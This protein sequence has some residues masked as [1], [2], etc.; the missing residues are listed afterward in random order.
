M[1]CQSC[2]VC[3]IICFD[4]LTMKRLA[5]IGDRRDK[6]KHKHNS[7][8][9]GCNVLCGNV[10]RDLIVFEIKALIRRSTEKGAVE[11]SAAVEHKCIHKQPTRNVCSGCLHSTL[12]SA[13]A[14]QN[15]TISC[16]IDDGTFFFC[17]FLS[18]VDYIRFDFKS[19]FEDDPIGTEEEHFGKRVRFVTCAPAPS[20]G[21]SIFVVGTR[22]EQ[23]MG[24]QCQRLERHV[25]SQ[26]PEPDSTHPNM[27]QFCVV[28]LKRH[29][30]PTIPSHTS[31][32]PWFAYG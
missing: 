12:F 18:M 22:W 6:D 11:Y 5:G 2:A 16:A 32:P 29:T 25:R 1:H 3:V 28:E 31:G 19:P 26:F 27:A 14:F 8:G 30:K 17:N 20:A 7:P 4:E 10:K 24:H 9:S 13:F 23:E 21:G 15:R